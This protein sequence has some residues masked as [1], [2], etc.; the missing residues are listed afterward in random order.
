MVV[1]SSSLSLFVYCL[2]STLF[3]SFPL[4][5]HTHTLSL[6][7]YV[8]LSPPF[9]FPPLTCDTKLPQRCAHFA[10]DAV[11]ISA[12]ATPTQDPT[13]SVSPLKQFFV[14][15]ITSLILYFKFS[16]SSFLLLSCLHFPISTHADGSYNMPCI[17]DLPPLSLY[18]TNHGPYHE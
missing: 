13:A 11:R 5:M 15:L 16:L 14:R 10:G 3:L 18:H 9:I 2:F 6:S 4:R 17:Y 12:A 1:P 8:S 7:L